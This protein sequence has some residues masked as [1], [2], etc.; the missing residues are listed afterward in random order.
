MRNEKSKRVERIGDVMKCLRCGKDVPE[1]TKYCE[2]CGFD[3]E[4]QKDYKTVYKEVDPILE[5]KKK[6]ALVD[7]PVLTFLFGIIAMMN[8]IMYSVMGSILLIITFCLFF[9]SCFF[10]STRQTKV[11]LKPFRE[12]GIIIGFLALAVMII[13]TIQF[14]I[15]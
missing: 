3:V 7:Y 15:A 6:V 4:S 13:S 9:G 10:F 11:K 5:G 12:V 8:A 2:N 1:N 14:L